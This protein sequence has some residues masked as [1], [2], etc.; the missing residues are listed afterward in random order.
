MQAGF[1]VAPQAP[2][3]TQPRQMVQPLP[4]GTERTPGCR[5]AIRCGARECDHGTGPR[6]IRQ[7]FRRRN[8]LRA[9]KAP[10]RPCLS[11]RTTTSKPVPMPGL[12]AP[13]PDPSTAVAPAAS[14]GTMPAGAAVAVEKTADG[15]QQS[16]EDERPVKSRRAPSQLDQGTSVAESSGQPAGAN[17]GLLPVPRSAAETP[18]KSP[19]GAQAAPFA[20]EAAETGRSIAGTAPA[21]AMAPTARDISG[22][23]AARS[24]PRS[25]S[26][27]R[28]P[29]D[30]PTPSEPA[31]AAFFN[32]STTA[33]MP[34]AYAAAT[35]A[36][37]ATVATVGTAD[38]AGWMSVRREPRS[39]GAEPA[40]TGA[41]A[42]GATV[43]AAAIA[44]PTAAA[45]TPSAYSATT[46]AAPAAVATVGIADAAGWETL[47]SEP[48]S[49][50]AGPAPTVLPH[51]AEA[52]Q[53]P[54]LA[55]GQA[56]QAASSAQHRPAAAQPT[57]ASNL[58]AS[59]PTTASQDPGQPATVPPTATTV[60]ASSIAEATATGAAISD[61]VG[62]PRTPQIVRSEAAASSPP[63]QQTVPSPLAKASCRDAGSVRALGHDCGRFPGAALGRSCRRTAR[64][65]IPGGSLRDQNTGQPWATDRRGANTGRIT[66]VRFRKP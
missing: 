49:T 14:S 16:T 40:A 44:A 61:A 52:P 27:G 21:M 42:P 20:A 37:P 25:T 54:I 56:E 4:T 10:R 34:M 47:R 58:A 59:P 24:E 41:P 63:V 7:R 29:T 35:N 15:E 45:D 57:S 19:H 39:T 28:A 31:G 46:N 48:R 62:Q 5:G 12:P 13:P 6:R 8:P 33:H 53:H 30:V 22:R 17:R 43:P 38:T 1:L 51:I 18:R 36:A 55:P 50:S 65:T 2:V 32:T 3:A 23:P 26:A 60:T 66:P 11:L 64:S 9:G